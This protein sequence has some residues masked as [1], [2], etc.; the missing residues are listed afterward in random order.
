[1]E[2]PPGRR[3]QRRALGHAPRPT[4]AADAVPSTPKRHQMLGMA[5]VAAHPQETMLT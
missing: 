1:M 3:D 5:G 2:V 4:N